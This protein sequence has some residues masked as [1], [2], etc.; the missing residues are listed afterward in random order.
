[1]TLLRDIFQASRCPWRHF[2]AFT[3]QIFALE[4]C[5]E[6]FFTGT[7]VSVPLEETSSCGTLLKG[8]S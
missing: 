1:M 8:C 5:Q 3:G 7:H 2:V 4:Q 6:P